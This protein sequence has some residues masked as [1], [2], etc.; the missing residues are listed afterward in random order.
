MCC[1][2]N[3]LWKGQL[4]ENHHP[5]T[6]CRGWRVPMA[7]AQQ[8]EGLSGQRQGVGTPAGLCEGWLQTPK[9]AA[10]R[11]RPD[12]CSL[13]GSGVGTRGIWV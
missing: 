7:W 4:S 3:R 12:R 13:D 2:G 10:G 1:L 5:S 9:L 8:G 6:P 11:R